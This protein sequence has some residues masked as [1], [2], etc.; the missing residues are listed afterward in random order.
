MSPKDYSKMLFEINHKNVKPISKYDFMSHYYLNTLQ[1]DELDRLIKLLF[2]NEP[3][4]YEVINKT[5]ID[6]PTSSGEII[7]L[8]QQIEK[9]GLKFIVPIYIVLGMFG[10]LKMSGHNVDCIVEKTYLT[11]N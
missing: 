8:F 6:Y 2:E 3:I 11:A 4:A 10:E 1:M 5:I 7:H 9:R